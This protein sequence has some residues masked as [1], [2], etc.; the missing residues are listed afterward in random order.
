MKKENIFK[1]PALI[2]YLV[3]KFNEKHPHKQIGNTIVQKMMYLL[4][5]QNIVDFNYSMYHY[6]PYSSEVSR[7]LNFS[8]NTGIVGS[9]WNTDKGR[10]IWAKET[11][12]EFEEFIE[13]EEKDSI[14]KIIDKYGKY[15]ATDL[16]I[17]ATG[18]YLRDRYDIPDEKLVEKVHSLKNKYTPEIIKKLLKD[19]GILE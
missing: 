11:L 7:E 2:G 12:D 1:K 14:N 19:S 5:R 13:E 10:N 8:E 3:K 18:F 15:R 16:A 6:G 4:S 9:I 17:I